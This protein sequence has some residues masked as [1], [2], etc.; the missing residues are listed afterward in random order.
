MKKKDEG[1]YTDA[2]IDAD[3]FMTSPATA[4]HTNSTLRE[5]ITQCNLRVE[6]NQQEF[7]RRLEETLQGEL[8]KLV[9]ELAI[10]PDVRRELGLPQRRRVK[11]ITPPKGKQFAAKRAVQKAQDFAES[12]G[13][14]RTDIDAVWPILYNMAKIAAA[15]NAAAMN[16]AGMNAAGMNAAAMSGQHFQKTYPMLVDVK[17]NDIVYRT[18]GTHVLTRRAVK[19]FIEPKKI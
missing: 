19:K 16:A 17:G 7:T 4:A 3:Q 8:I 15:M 13:F 14:S 10:D 11:Q 2:G 12:Q 9:D 5:H 6:A 1:F 18:N